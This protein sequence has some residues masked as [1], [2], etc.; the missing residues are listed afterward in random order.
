MRP[1][2]SIVYLTKNGGH[3][4]RESLEAVF[5]QKVDFKF[6]V[7]AVDSGSTDGTLELLEQFPVKVYRIAA[8]EFN[9]GITRDYGFNLAQGDVVVAI[10]QDAVPVGKEWLQDMVSPF[11]DESIAAVQGCDILPEEKD[12]FYWDK[13]RFFY[14]T[15][16]CKRWLEAHN[17]I[18]MSFTCCAIRKTVWEENQLGWVEMSEDKVFQ[19]GIMAKGL[20]IYGQANAKIYHSH[21]YSV[22]SLAKRCENEGL[23]W[24]N[25]AQDYSFCDMVRDIFNREII[26]FLWSGIVTR[27]IKQLSELLFPL[28]RPV[29]V[30]KGNHFTKHYKKQ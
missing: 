22:S 19:R 9:F 13:I 5:S 25:V 29:Y 26:R 17:N 24:K 4:L 3:L 1:L 16:E 21:R 6:E 2:A 10:S 15:L 18:G 20:K 8:N 11:E 7:I 27:E 23:G 28:I 14:Y 12:L 30:Y